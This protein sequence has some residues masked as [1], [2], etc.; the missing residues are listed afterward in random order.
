MPHLNEG[1]AT[2]EGLYD[3]FSEAFAELVDTLD[4]CSDGRSDGG[5]V[6]MAES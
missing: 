1:K 2:P 4:D 3:H 6:I 5:E